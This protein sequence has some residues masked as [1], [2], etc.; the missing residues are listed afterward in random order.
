MEYFLTTFA[1]NEEIVQY[2]IKH[3]AHVITEDEYKL[4]SLYKNARVETRTQNFRNAKTANDPR[5]LEPEKITEKTQQIQKAAISN[6][7]YFQK[8]TVQN[9]PK[10]RKSSIPKVSN[11]G[12]SN[13]GHEPKLQKEKR[14]KD[15]KFQI[16]RTFVSAI[17]NLSR[18]TPQATLNFLDRFSARL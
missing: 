11:R 16:F 15:L 10:P 9:V 3:G 17:F 7:S 14:Q 5:L 6:E 13:I 12:K 8:S 4:A 2:L 18:L 1:G